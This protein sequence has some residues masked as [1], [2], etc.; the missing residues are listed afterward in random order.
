MVPIEILDGPYTFPALQ[1]LKRRWLLPDR[2]SNRSSAM[3][4]IPLNVNV[5]CSDVACGK[6]TNVII[7]PVT[8]QVT[9]VVVEDKSLPANPTRLVPVENVASTTH[10][11]ITLSCSKDDVAHMRPFI[12]TRFIRQSASGQAYSSGQ[13]YHSQY[14]LNDTAYDTVQEEDIPQSELAVYGGMHI[15]ASDGN[16]GKLDEL[17][18][19]PKSGDITHLQMREGHLWGKKD[20]A[21]PVSAVDFVDEDTIYLKLV[22]EDVK[23]LPAVSVKRKAG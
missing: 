14:V 6:T 1:P 16:V 9:H 18:L 12:V 22:K 4:N 5:Q 13:A 7:N 23:A 11:Q 19:D 17:V 3:T 21:I 20:V 8:H 10:N 15:E 2:T